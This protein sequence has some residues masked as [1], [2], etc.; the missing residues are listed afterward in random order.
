MHVSARKTHD[1]RRLAQHV[2][3]LCVS[4]KIAMRSHT[5]GGRAS[6]RRST[7]AIRLVR[8]EVTYA[9]ALHEI[10]HIAGPQ[11]RGMLNRE[12][13]AWLWAK[14]HALV[15]TDAMSATMQ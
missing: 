12:V 3:Q 7:I 1:A 4:A 11:V 13:E 5:S 2:D 8:S 14:R 6:V 9:V 10:G 15:W